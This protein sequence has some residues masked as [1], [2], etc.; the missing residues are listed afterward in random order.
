MTR[1]LFFLF[2]LPRRG[3]HAIAQTGRL[4]PVRKNM[5]EMTAAR[6]AQHFGPRHHEFSIGLR[7]D[8]VLRERFVETWPAAPGFKFRFRAEEWIFATETFV[9]AGIIR[10]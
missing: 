4:R 1:G 7:G 10:L 8:S 6:S 9:N 2:Q 5:T 3:V